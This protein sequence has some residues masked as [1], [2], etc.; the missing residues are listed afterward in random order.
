MKMRTVYAIAICSWAVVLSLIGFASPRDIGLFLI[1][2]GVWAGVEGFL[3]WRKI[4]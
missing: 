3:K 1:G 4:E 2:C